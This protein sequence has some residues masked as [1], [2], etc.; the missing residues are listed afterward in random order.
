MIR[1]TRLNGTEFLINPDLIERIETTP[2]TVVVL[3]NGNK[4]LVREPADQVDNRIVAF[5]SR[6]GACP[7]RAVPAGQED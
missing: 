6:C 2:Q 5:R 3:N 1:V 4:Y 7:E